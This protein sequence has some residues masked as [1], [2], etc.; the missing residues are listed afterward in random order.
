MSAAGTAPP[1]IG[2][3][4]PTLDTQR[5]SGKELKALAIRAEALSFDSL[6]FVDH[7]LIAEHMLGAT[8]WDPLVALPYIAGCTDRIQLGTSVMIAPLRHQLWLLKQLGTISGAVGERVLLGLGVGYD[9]REFAAAEVDRSTRGQRLDAVLDALA[10]ARRDG[11]LSVRGVP[12]SP[13]PSCWAAVLVG[14]GGSSR[15]E[16]SGGQVRMTEKV[17]TRIARA[18]GWVAR[19]SAPPDMMRADQDAIR[20]RRR[21]LALPDE[22][23]TVRATFLHLSTAGDAERALTEQTQAMTASGWTGTPQALRNAYPTGTI[24]EIVEWLRSEVASGVDH[25]ILHPV[26]N[27]AEQIELLGEHVLGRV[28]DVAREARTG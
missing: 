15:V 13:A 18:D 4:L 24:D 5:P 27:V 22:F 16:D 21:E 28:K 10:M 2:I 19:S 6:W 3:R 20:A 14:G 26:G 8:S 12:V 7:L 17:L 23:R 9:E 1:S 25:L 11:V